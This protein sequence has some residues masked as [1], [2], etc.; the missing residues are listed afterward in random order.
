MF[1]FCQ[2][3]STLPKPER[4]NQYLRFARYAQIKDITASLFADLFVLFKASQHSSF[5]EN[6][7]RAILL[8]DIQIL[9]RLSRL[10]HI[11]SDRQPNLF[12]RVQ[13]YGKTIQIVPLCLLAVS[14]LI[15][16]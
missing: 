6:R 5:Q 3:N 15:C 12:Q 8:L 16:Q 14:C 4:W 1:G 13:L 7:E 2:D 11:F 10:I 9:P